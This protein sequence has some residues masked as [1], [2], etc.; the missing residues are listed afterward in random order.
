[1][2]KNTTLTAV[3]GDMPHKRFRG[4]RAIAIVA[5]GLLLAGAGGAY[6]FYSTTGAGTGSAKNAPGN[7]TLVLTASFAPGLTPGAS[8]P[9]TFTVTNP[10]TS[11]LNLNTI[12][13]VVSTSPSGC[14]P[15]DFSISPVVVDIRV[16]GTPK[17][18][19]AVP[20][21]IQPTG[22]LAFADTALNQDL[23]KD[24]VVTLTL[25]SN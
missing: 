16:P 21:A 24:A 19:A 14:L 3:T 7:G 15:A 17:N 23:C 5:A 9:V 18:Q 22:T 25:S 13:S 11:T 12:T 1:M 10:G 20:V 6:A 4:K 2:T 8:T